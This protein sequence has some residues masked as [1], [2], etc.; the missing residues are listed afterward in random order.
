M[1][2]SLNALPKKRIWM[3][4]CL[5]LIAALLL[6]GGVVAAAGFAINATIPVTVTITDSGAPIYSDQG[7]SAPLTAL[8]F[9]YELRYAAT[10]QTQTGYVSAAA[11]TQ[12]S[13]PISV[14]APGMTG[15]GVTITAN[16]G[17]VTGAYR[18]ITFKAVGGTA[19][20]PLTENTVVF[21]LAA[22]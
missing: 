3:P 12:S 20:G 8:S 21:T 4:V 11:V 18:P 5:V 14:S 6:A 9:T 10:G 19:A 17:P 2:F 15:S 16:L 13:G 7:L 22:Q 1:K